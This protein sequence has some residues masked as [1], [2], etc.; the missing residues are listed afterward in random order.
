[1]ARGA[2]MADAVLALIR[3]AAEPCQAEGACATCRQPIHRNPATGLW[4]NRF[5][6]H[7]GPGCNGHEPFTIDGRRACGAPVDGGRCGRAPGHE[8]H[9]HIKEPAAES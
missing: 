2:G 8:G 4:V 1:V 6:Y 5:G 3:A 7:A 9:P